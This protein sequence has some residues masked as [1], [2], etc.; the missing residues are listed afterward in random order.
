MATL[1]GAVP[2]QGGTAA[3][4]AP[5]EEAALQT[6]Y[7]VRF[8][9][10]QRI[11]HILMI[12]SFLTLVLTGFPQK[13]DGLEISQWFMNGL[14][15]IDNVRLI[16]R[17][18]GGV[19]IFDGIYHISYLA[20]MVL[21]LGKVGALRMIPTPKDLEDAVQ[22]VYY[23]LGM[24]KEKPRYGRFTYL[25]KFDYWAVFWGMVI[26]GGSGLMLLFPVQVSHVLPGQAVIAAFRAHSDEALLAVTWIFVVHF[27]YAHLAPS[28]FPFNP[29]IFTG[30]TPA[31][32]YLED[33]PL[34]FEELRESGL[35][36][37]LEAKPD[38]APT[39]GP[40]T[41][42][43]E[44]PATAEEEPAS[45]QDGKPESAPGKQPPE[46]P[47]QEPSETDQEDESTDEREA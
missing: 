22:T 16:H 35:V 39:S 4:A 45:D 20:Y 33:H 31:R 26:M 40:P 8:D 6:A 19:L 43:G 28:V 29:S 9:I 10:H 30:R 37:G 12:T 17:I 18:A 5:V 7:V 23:F 21:I 27:F 42:E 41:P 32:R 15:G 24:A 13:F 11:Q 46:G 38:E 25:E 44:A 14:G 1:P 47:G 36:V 34:E 2:E 3:V